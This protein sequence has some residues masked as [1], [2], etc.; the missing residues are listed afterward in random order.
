MFIGQCI[1]TLYCVWKHGK[2]LYP[3]ES[4]EIFKMFLLVAMFDS[5]G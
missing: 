4:M 1:L 5:L 3:C 2:G